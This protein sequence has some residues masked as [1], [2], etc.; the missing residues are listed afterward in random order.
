LASVHIHIIGDLFFAEFVP[1][2][3]S[4]AGEQPAFEIERL[5]DYQSAD[6]GGIWTSAGGA[7]RVASLLGPHVDSLTLSAP[8]G[9]ASALEAL[10][11][12]RRTRTGAPIKLNSLRE[13]GAIA[14]VLRA[15]TKVSSQTDEDTWELAFRLECP[16]V[17]TSS[18]GMARLDAAEAFVLADYGRGAITA[19]VLQEVVGH[20]P[21]HLVIFATNRDAEV[22]EHLARSAANIV[23]ICAD[24]SALRWTSL[25]TPPPA[26]FPLEDP[27]DYLELLAL[28]LVGLSQAFPNV[29]YFVVICEPDSQRCFVFARDPATG[30]WNVYFCKGGRGDA[31]STRERVPGS[32]SAFLAAFTRNLLRDGAGDITSAVTGATRAGIGCVTQLLEK[33]I[34]FDGDHF[35]RPEEIDDEK[36]V[37]WA[38]TEF[39][40]TFEQDI[41]EVV[42][43]TQMPTGLLR[44]AQLYGQLPDIVETLPGYYLPDS[45]RENVHAVVNTLNAYVTRRNHKRPFN[46]LLSA[47]P[48]S[49]KSH[50][51][52]CLAR[53]LTELAK[54]GDELHPLLEF[55]LSAIGN[56]SLFED[57]LLDIYQD[58][59]DERAAGRIPI[60]LLDEFDSLLTT[61]GDDANTQMLMIFAKMLAPLWD[62]VFAFAKKTRR[63]GGFVLIMVVSDEKFMEVLGKGKGKDFESR[64]D[65]H[66]TLPEPRGDEKLENQVRVALPMLRKHFGDTVTH[67]ELAVLDAIGRATF[68]RRNRGIDQLFLLSTRPLDRTFR[69]QHL[70]P[71]TL[72]DRIA[73]DLDLEASTKRFGRSVIRCT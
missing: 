57:Q 6:F 27:S 26:T 55:N 32:G 21:N 47:L 15:Y 73:K 7:A 36:S 22:Y 25:P 60:V 56:A 9:K 48:G 41:A 44:H 23:V 64:I 14:R 72:I 46:M 69:V 12:A 67:V 33:G 54:T 20:K 13:Q 58:V 34:I 18:A 3:S 50:F 59:R 29:H 63:L 70:A 30:C 38:T 45:Q 10:L 8:L 17:L 35:G 24:S 71:P 66:F 2:K 37:P 42:S 19:S 68:P 49:G 40:T 1:V 5:T 11:D 62:G 43:A 31:L 39:L 65:I 61:S 28:V 4:S 51:V 16:Q 52:Q 53:R